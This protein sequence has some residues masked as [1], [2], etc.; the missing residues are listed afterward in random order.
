MSGP[1]ENEEKIR[2][3]LISNMYPGTGRCI[4][5]VFIRNIETGLV[6][7][8]VHV[9]RIVIAGRGDGWMQKIGKYVRFYFQILT[10]SLRR[11]DVVQVSYP[12]HSFLPLI[13]R[14][15]HETRLVVRLHGLD[16][17]GE[18]EDTLS[19]KLG[20]I[21]T[22]LAI[23]RADLVVVP[24]R[25][26]ESELKRRHQ[27]GKVHVYPSGGV[28]LHL[29]YPASEP[30]VEP[31]VACV[32]R[33]DR[34]KG[35]DVLIRSL[36]QTRTPV[37][38]RIVG[39]GDLREELKQL[40]VKLGV[41]KRI[42]FTGLVEHDQLTREYQK[43][44]VFVFPTMRRAE[45]FGNVAME[46]MACGLPVIGSKIAGLTDYV[47]HGENGWFF[48]PGDVRGLA[49]ALDRFFALSAEER[50]RMREAAIK[51]ASGYEQGRVSDGFVQELRS[52][53][54]H[55]SDGASPS[56]TT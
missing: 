28:D 21:F 54:P 23:R 7:R 26:F 22:R 44:A 24:S 32:G 51:T 15:F 16:L 20:R 1:H 37:A 17:L 47:K 6:R 34:L 29:F 9:D 56:R 39:E 49:R 5:G 36:A 30:V 14:R 3:L 11:Y 48:E 43:A 10:A 52:M 4:Y 25:Y 40:A 27:T 42:T 41:D 55:Q 46:A 53:L 13:L 33:L 35:V 12:S 38:A 8:G 19:H 50:K 31:V 2:F 18:G 45:S